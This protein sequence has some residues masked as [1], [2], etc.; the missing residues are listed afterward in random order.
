MGTGP[1]RDYKSTSGALK[2]EH[3]MDELRDSGKKFSEEDVVMI[4]KQKDGELL[5]LEKGNRK[6]GLQ[7]IVE[8]HSSNL[9]DAFGVTENEIP[10]F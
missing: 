1:G 3:L 9:E 4:A 6:V 5:W 10:Y 2:P 7:H 8:R